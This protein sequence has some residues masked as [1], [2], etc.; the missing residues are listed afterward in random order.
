MRYRFLSFDSMI[1]SIGRV[2]KKN[3]A[4]VFILYT[5]KWT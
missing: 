5:S 4:F 2:G 3:G 1:Q